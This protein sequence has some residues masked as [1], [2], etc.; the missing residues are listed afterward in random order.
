MEAA[1]VRRKYSLLNAL[2]VPPGNRLEALKVDRKGQHSIR[3]NDQWRICFKWKA[4]DAYD[5]EIV[6]YHCYRGSTGWPS[7]KR[8]TGTQFECSLNHRGDKLPRCAWLDAPGTLHL[9]IVRGIERRRIVNDVV[10]R[11]YVLGHHLL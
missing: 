7:S 1:R 10:G 5:V 2:R 9:T 6:D 3:I 4:G 11:G 8:G